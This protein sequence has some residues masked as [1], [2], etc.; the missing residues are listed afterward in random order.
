MTKKY[1]QGNYP[2]KFTAGS[3]A[4]IDAEIILEETGYENCGASRSYYPNSSIIAKFRYLLARFKAWFGLSKNSIVFLQ[5]PSTKI[6]KFVT[7]AKKRDC[8]I[9]MLIHDLKSP[10]G[11]VLESEFQC[12]ALADI[13]IVHT[14]AMKN[15]LISHG[16]TKPIV[17]LEIFDYLKASKSDNSNVYTDIRVGFAGNLGKSE[18]IDN[19][20]FHNITFK[21]F[22]IG[23]E[24]RRLNHGVEYEGCFPPD[25]L[26]THMSVH[27]GLVWD[28]ISADNCEGERGNYLKVI[29]PHKLSMYLSAGIPSIVWEHSAMA[30]F[31]KNNNIGLTIKS[32]K[33]LEALLPSISEEKYNEMKSNIKALS[34]KL[35]NGFYLTKAIREAETILRNSNN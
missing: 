21:L 20:T 30:K 26:A 10:R 27:Y 6:L 18:F 13:L 29:A 23:I 5:F 19:V 33:E 1:F 34:E 15:W 31:I 3:K 8:K 17:T 2:D 7:L 24:K 22:G 16:V 14:D 25:Q 28:G 32:L 35:T 4:K 12:M 11:T 9:I